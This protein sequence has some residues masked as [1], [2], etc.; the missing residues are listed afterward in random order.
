MVEECQ[1]GWA[2][3]KGCK[4]Q[5]WG[6]SKTRKSIKLRLPARVL[7]AVESLSFQH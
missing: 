4:A 3:S 2:S 7:F 1:Y 6:S 5:A